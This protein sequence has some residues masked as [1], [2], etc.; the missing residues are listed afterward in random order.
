MKQ[1]L[2]AVTILLLLI[3]LL[4]F[5]VMLVRDLCD[6]LLASLEALPEDPGDRAAEGLEALGQ[7]WEKRS[8]IFELFYPEERVERARADF[9][10]MKE[11]ADSG[12]TGAYRNAKEQL[13]EDLKELRESAGPSW[14]KL[15]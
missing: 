5:S 9:L 13:R 11:F 2:V 1:F 7:I 10:S 4:L 15:F 8:W 3:L 6:E 12:E 14:K